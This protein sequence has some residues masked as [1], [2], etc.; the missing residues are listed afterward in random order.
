MKNALVLL[1]TLAAAASPGGCRRNLPSS[2]IVHGRGEDAE[3]LDPQAIDDGE[4]AKV[5]N[6]IF[7]GLVAFGPGSCEIQPC[8]A[9]SWSKSD[10]GLVWTFRLRKGVKFHDGTP[11]DAEAVAFTMARLL[12]EKSAF[13]PDEKVPYASFYRGIVASVEAKDPGTVVFRLARSYAPF[14]ANMAMFSADMVSPAAVRAAGP[15]AFGKSPVG[16]GPFR[17]ESWSQGEKKIVLARNPDY[18]RGPAAVDTVVFRTI[19]DKNTRLTA[20]RSGDL[21]WMDT[22]NCED[23]EPCRKDPRLK[24]WSGTGM[25]VGYLAMNTERKPF[26]DVR[27][28]RAVSLAVDRKRLVDALYY[29]SAVPAVH[30]MPPSMLGYDASVPLPA[31]DPAKAKALLAEAGFPGGFDTDL[32]AMSNDRPYFPSPLKIAEVLKA[33]LGAAGIRVKIETAGDFSLYREA[34]SNGRHSIGMLGWTGDNGDPDNFLF[35]FFAKENAVKGPGALNVSFWVDPRMQDLLRRGQEET[36]G[37]KRAA[38]YREALALVADQVP[39]VPVA[40][41]ETVFVSK[42]GFEGFHV[43]PTGDLLFHGVK[44]PPGE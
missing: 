35:T 26:D 38:V 43:Q 16:T 24:V 13:K 1:L 29:G 14:L 39:L 23:I 10:D 17:F 36:D 28:R 30:P 41:A 3:S 42:A 25:N 34:L 40:H 20:L 33:D 7:D 6:N 12:D 9:E 2:I 5:C 31:A 22:P 21:N 4:S 37:E 32:F 19:P 15:K 44:P 11:F 27:V 18:W 8:L